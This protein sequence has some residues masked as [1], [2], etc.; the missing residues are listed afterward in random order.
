MIDL[1]YCS[2]KWEPWGVRV[3]FPDGV[4]ADGAPHDTAHYRVIAHRLG[5]G[6]DI[7]AY[8]REHD[9]CH[10]YVEQELHRRPSRVLRGVAV[11]KYAPTADAV[12]EEIMAQTLQ[13]W[14]RTNERPIV[15]GCDWDAL[16]RGA[17]E[18]L[19]GVG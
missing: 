12:Y 10:A 18:L 11:G 9:F 19:D 5:Y 4:H 1:L 6:D 14:L 8:A 7:M 2:V 3:L 15:S 17:L 13:R 16:R